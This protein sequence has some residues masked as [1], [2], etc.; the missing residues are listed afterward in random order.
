[1]GGECDQDLGQHN[2][3]C[4]VFLHNTAIGYVDTGY[5]MDCEKSLPNALVF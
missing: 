2:S 1:M 4:V 3:L 5:K